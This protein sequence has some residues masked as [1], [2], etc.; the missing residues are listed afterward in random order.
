MAKTQVPTRLVTTQNIMGAPAFARGFEDA[1]RGVPFDW[2]VGSTNTD[3]A[4]DYERGR[5]LAHI[6]PLDMPL[7]IG[8]GLN[9]KAIALCDAAFNRKLIT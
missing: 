9:P 5:L 8:G 1:R 6:A 4:W 3:D 7:R 2:R